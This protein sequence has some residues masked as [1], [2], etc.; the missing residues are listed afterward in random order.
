MSLTP[1]PLPRAQLQQMRDTA[2]RQAR[3]MSGI[4]A[5]LIGVALAALAMVAFIVLDYHFEQPLHRIIKLFAGA[6]LGIT[7]VTVPFVGLLA[8]PV[9]TPFLSWIPPVPLPGVNAL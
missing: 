6:T 2:R 1:R 4:G 8:Y 9:V 3:T 5:A 7:V